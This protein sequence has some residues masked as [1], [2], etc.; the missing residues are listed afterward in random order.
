MSKVKPL[1]S[2]PFFPRICVHSQGLCSLSR[3]VPAPSGNSAPRAFPTCGSAF[4]LLHIDPNMASTS[5]S[6]FP[7][8]LSY[9]ENPRDGGPWWAAIYGV[10]QSQTRLKRL[11]S[12][13]NSTNTKHLR[14]GSSGSLRHFWLIQPPAQLAH[15]KRG[16][17]AITVSS[18]ADLSETAE[19]HLPVD[20]NARLTRVGSWPFLLTANVPSIGFF[21]PVSQL[22]V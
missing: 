18:S 21:F 12:S 2:F 4:S 5:C 10:A 7:Q 19:I 3:S 22:F 15:P 1:I 13:S 16:R 20:R 17:S 9:L 8:E 11:S 6:Q 14:A